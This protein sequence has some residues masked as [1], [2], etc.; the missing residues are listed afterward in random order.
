MELIRW[1]LH[2]G[3]PSGHRRIMTML[4]VLMQPML[5]LSI[6]S[7]VSA[8][9][10]A[11][12]P[13]VNTPD[14]ITL[15]SLCADIVTEGVNRQRLIDPGSLSSLV[16]D[17]ALDQSARLH[18]EDMIARSY[19]D[20]LSPDGLTPH[21]RITRFHRG[22]I[23]EHSGENIW[24]HRHA[25]RD[26]PLEAG[27]Q[28]M[29]QWMASTPHRANILSP[30]YTHIGVAVVRYAGDVYAVQHFVGSRGV[31]IPEIPETIRRGA[32]LMTSVRTH[33]PDF[34]HLLRFDLVDPQSLE[35][36]CDPTYL[37]IGHLNAPAGLFRIRL[38][39]LSPDEKQWDIYLG[40][41]VTVP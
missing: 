15:E 31:L 37:R 41:L 27:R 6:V 24:L 40:P 7:A 8:V 12:T 16:R 21:D 4:C 33:D 26:T 14:V 28:M 20:H 35:S 38:Y 18:I 29:K 39:F 17:P 1:P 2:A 34:M 9:S 32:T 25:T 19:F 10:A 36:A 3:F 30:L 5:F 23:I 22:L 13:K 11:S